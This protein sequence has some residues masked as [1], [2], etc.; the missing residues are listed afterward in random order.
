MTLSP[1]A[2]AAIKAG[3]K[4]EAIKLVREQQNLGLKEAKARVEA[5]ID[6]QPALKAE[7]Q[8]S[9]VRT[10]PGLSGWIAFAC[11][12]VIAWYFIRNH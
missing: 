3:R 7:M 6:S 1:E 12:A 10:L 11:V 4:I 8:A 2:I 9:A 5:Y